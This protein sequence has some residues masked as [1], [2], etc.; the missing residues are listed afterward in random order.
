M[1]AHNAP[2]GPVRRSHTR[3]DAPFGTVTLMR[4]PRQRLAASLLALAVPALV[5]VGC[6]KNEPG[7][8]TAA[9]GT[10]G[11]TQTGGT[12]PP[13]TGGGTGT[14]PASN[15]PKSIDLKGKNPCDLLTP[16]VRQKLGLDRPPRGGNTVGVYKDAPYCSS[17]DSAHDVSVSIGVATAMGIGEYGNLPGDVKPTSVASYPAMT[18]VAPGVKDQCSVAVDVA[19]GQFLFAIFADR[20]ATPR[21]VDQLCAGA[22][23]VGELALG[24]LRG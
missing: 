17:Q 13:T 6:S 18:A 4:S 12:T 16:D 7:N 20:S 1:P 19:D 2:F 21:P 15:R 23:R 5:I 3:A 24:V 22:V 11:S 8:P 10:S 14:T 9:P